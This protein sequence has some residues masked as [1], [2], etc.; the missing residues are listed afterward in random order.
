MFTAGRKLLVCRSIIR[1]TVGNSGWAPSSFEEPAPGVWV[2][3][4][5]VKPRRRPAHG[6]LNSHRKQHHCKTA[7]PSKAM[8]PVRKSGQHRTPVR[9]GYQATEL[10]RQPAGL[11]APPVLLSIASSAFY[12]HVQGAAVFPWNN[13]AADD[14]RVRHAAFPGSTGDKDRGSDGWR[15]MNDCTISTKRFEVGKV[16]TLRSR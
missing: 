1:T 12:F 10:S 5:D 16:E 2:N 4:R 11:P 9:L 3:V 15:R 8:R 14:Y 6:E 7:K 13:T